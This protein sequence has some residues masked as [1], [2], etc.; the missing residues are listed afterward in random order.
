MARPRP[1]SLPSED[2]PRSAAP[3]SVVKTTSP[4][5]S[6]VA[7]AA[8][9]RDGSGVRGT[10]GVYSSRG[11][12][13]RRGAASFGGAGGRTG[14]T[15]AGAGGAGGDG[16]ADVGRDPR[17]RA[18]RKCRGRQ[19]PTRGDLVVVGSSSLIGN[20]S[21]AAMPPLPCRSGRTRRA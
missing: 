11:G 8:L 1:R 16:A 12:L 14:G 13:V 21:P 7:N 6:D 4:P 17:N 20:A 9:R 18:G 19:S 2:P 3:P 15:A 10:N 5:T